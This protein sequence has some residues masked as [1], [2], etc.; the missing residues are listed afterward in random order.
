ML[1]RRYETK[2]LM[3]RTTFKKS[4]LIIIEFNPVV[5]RNIPRCFRV[6]NI[7]IA[8]INN[9]SIEIKIRAID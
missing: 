3:E 8:P 7:S 6:F 5:K 4:G 9:N 1:I 2:K